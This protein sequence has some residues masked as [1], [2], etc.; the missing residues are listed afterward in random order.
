MLS[1]PVA[2]QLVCDGCSE[3]AGLCV[4]ETPTLT[5]WGVPSAG[6]VPV[7][8]LSCWIGHEG[9]EKSCRVSV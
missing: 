5:R 6:L 8:G 9:D 7:E 3:A 2:R 4:P 1:K